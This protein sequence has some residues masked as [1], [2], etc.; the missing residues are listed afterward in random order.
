MAVRI[1]IWF[2]V[3]A[4]KEGWKLVMNVLKSAVVDVLGQKSYIE[5]NQGLKTR[6]VH[7]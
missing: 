3:L 2:N 6:P 4:L 5:K 7:F 1:P